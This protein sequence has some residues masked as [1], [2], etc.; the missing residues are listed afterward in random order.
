MTFSAL[1][2]N[3]QEHFSQTLKLAV[4]IVIGQVGHVMMGFVDNAIVGHVSPINLAA[5]SLANGFFFVIMVVGLGITYIISPLVSMAN[6][7]GNRAESS[8][9]VNNGFF[10]NLTVGILLSIITYFASTLIGY[11]HQP[12]EVTALAIPYCRL[13]GVTAIPMML[14]QNYRQFLEGLSIM[15]PAMYITL[16]ANIVN[17]AA[18]YI[19]V[20][21]KFGFPAMGLQG[22][23]F[24]TL[25][26]RTSMALVII[27]Y[28]LKSDRCREF[29]L[30]PF[31]EAID[32]GLIRKI[33]KLGLGSG[34][35]YF[36]EVACFAFAAYMAGWLGAFPLAA[37]Q[38]ALNMASITY[39]AVVGISAAGAIRVSGAIGAG[40]RLLARRA[41]F[42][43]IGLAFFYMLCTATLLVLL[44]SIIPHIYVS[45]PQVIAIAA[46]LLFIAALFQIFDGVQATG[47]GVLRGMTDVKI[48]TVITFIAYWVISIPLAYFLGFILKFGIQ[49]IWVGLLIGLA[50]S[51]SLLFLR[52]NRISR[53]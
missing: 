48:P 38:I 25:S 10:V 5:A 43:A 41:G 2:S 31:K 7:A 52:F 27:Y 36:F 28:I 34:F 8:K 13:I 33:L 3:Y 46:K 19:F 24:A 35:Q 9:I 40:N 26:A 45:E 1:K 53:A 29:Q 42:S 4:P 14:F 32:F 44:K 20:F 16:G 18:N 11:M 17:A 22:S 21:G 30:N 51:A 15:R 6:G 49:G 50:S 47:L 23:G 12:A 39:M 37:H